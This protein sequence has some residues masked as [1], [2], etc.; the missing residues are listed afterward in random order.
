MPVFERGANHGG[1]RPKACYG[2]VYPP[3]LPVTRGHVP[4]VH[5]LR[6][7]MDC[8]VKPGNDVEQASAK[9]ALGSVSR[10][11]QP[12]RPVMSKRSWAACRAQTECPA[13]SEI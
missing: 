2:E 4:R 1:W 11:R 5:L 3:L 6:M 10:V 7:K 8:W 12:G 13:R 9:R